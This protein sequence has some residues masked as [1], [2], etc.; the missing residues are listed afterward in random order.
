MDRA[1][2]DPGELSRFRAECCSRVRKVQTPWT[3]IPMPITTLLH[4]ERIHVMMT[5]DAALLQLRNAGFTHLAV[6]SPLSE[7]P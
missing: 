3:Q 5:L 7:P 2:E 6:C 1:K 4:E